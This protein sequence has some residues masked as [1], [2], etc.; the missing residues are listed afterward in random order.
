MRGSAAILNYW[1]K[2]LVKLAYLHSYLPEIGEH[3]TMMGANQIASFKI[4]SSLSRSLDSLFHY[5]VL[6]TYEV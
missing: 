1:G 5:Q 3:N 2:E 6:V 4:F